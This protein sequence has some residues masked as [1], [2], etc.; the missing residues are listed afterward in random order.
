MLIAKQW[1]KCLLNG[2]ESI[3]AY[4]LFA[5]SRAMRNTNFK[6]CTTY[7]ITYY[8]HANNKFKTIF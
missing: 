2:I 8:S 4:F 5:F 7:F 1:W 3:I 6:L